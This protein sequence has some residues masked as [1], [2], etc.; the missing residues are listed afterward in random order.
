MIA[1][2]SPLRWICEMI[3]DD[4][5]GLHLPLHPALSNTSTLKA[6]SLCSPKTKRGITRTPLHFG[7]LVGRSTA[8]RS[9]M[10]GQ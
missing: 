9:V 4:A 10:C 7:K 1:A 5:D 3:L 6:N 2:P 8:K